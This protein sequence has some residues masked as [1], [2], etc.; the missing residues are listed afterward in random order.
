MQ[1]P[2]RRVITGEFCCRCES[3]FPERTISTHP[4]PLKCPV[5]GHETCA[6]CG[7]TTGTPDEKIT[8]VVM[9]K[10]AKP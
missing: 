8:T 5:C 3:T 4:F 9:G 2:E 6:H 7:L 10:K 1:Q